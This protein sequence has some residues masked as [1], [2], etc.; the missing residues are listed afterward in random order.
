MYFYSNLNEIIQ[1]SKKKDFEPSPVNYGH[2]W[3]F[4]GTYHLYVIGDIG[5]I[6]TNKLVV[7]AS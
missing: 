7:S 1:H 4:R 3:E 6:I 5:D 2:L